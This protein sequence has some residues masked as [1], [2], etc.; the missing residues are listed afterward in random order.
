[1][2]S[3][4]RTLRCSLGVERVEVLFEPVLGR[5][6]GIDPSSDDA[7]AGQPTGSLPGFDEGTTIPM[8]Q[9]HCNRAVHSADGSSIPGSTQEIL[10]RVSRQRQRLLTTVATASSRCV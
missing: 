7:N 1:M 2:G 5:F 8:G 3:E 10:F 4:R 9:I 6:P